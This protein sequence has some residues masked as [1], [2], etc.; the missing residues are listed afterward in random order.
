M[1]AAA[2]G[3]AAMSAR[4]TSEHPMVTIPA[5]DGRAASQNK[6]LSGVDAGKKRAL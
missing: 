3:A 1:P 5:D 6:A 4:L 2:D